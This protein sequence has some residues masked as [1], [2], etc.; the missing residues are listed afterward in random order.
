MRSAI[1]IEPDA[2]TARAWLE[3]ELA[4]D[5]YTVKPAGWIQQAQEWLANVF[6]RLFNVAGDGGLLSNPGAIVIVIIIVLVVAA[7]LYLILGPLRRSRR[8][9]SSG[10]MFEDDEREATEIRDAA[11]SAAERGDW[12]LA[13]IE[14]FRGLVRAVEERNLVLVVPGMT[15]HEFSLDVA[16]RLPQQLAALE[17][18]AEYFDGVRY[19]HDVADRSIYEF[20]VRT[21]E[22]IA[23]S[24]PQVPA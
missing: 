24:R 14:R 13:V 19:G 21:D 2:E 8:V 11:V 10:A 20:M 18:A 1:P 5:V 16:S 17:R 4:K 23:A 3:E 7:L 15:A 22:A 9:K 6:E 12:T